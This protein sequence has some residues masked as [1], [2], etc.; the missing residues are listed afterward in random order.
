MSSAAAFTHKTDAMR[1]LLNHVSRGYSRW[2]G[3][4]VPVGK[5][6]PMTLKFSDRYE[7]DRTPQMR[8]RAKKRGEANAQLVLW[9]ESK[10]DVRWW[11]VVSPGTGLVTTMES[12]MDAT[13][14]RTRVS[15]TGYEMVQTP[16]KN[17]QAQWTWRMTA[18]L[19]E[20]WEARLKEAIR[21]KND[22]DLRQSLHSLVRV[23]GFS[24][25]RRQAFK[26]AHFAQAEWRRA[27]REPWPYGDQY[28]GWLGRFKTGEKLEIVDRKRGQA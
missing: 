8:W 3:G 19:V 28:V 25:A 16:R 6:L 20:D 17:R 13:D 12:L 14:K 15:L 23:P 2:V 22:G 21:R 11:L 4:T 1:A 18:D 24:Q 5:V 27:R 7:I 9:T 10:E 26:L